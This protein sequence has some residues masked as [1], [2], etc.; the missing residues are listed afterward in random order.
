M[1][2]KGI[3]IICIGASESAYGPVYSSACW[4]TEHL[5]AAE[6]CIE[7]IMKA[8]LDEVAQLNTESSQYA[9]MYSDSKLPPLKERNRDRYKNNA[10]LSTL[11]KRLH[12]L[13]EAPY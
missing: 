10:A 9:T 13:S 6:L 8:G 4:I 7:S 3:L 12:P 2:R 1:E 5:P 11:F